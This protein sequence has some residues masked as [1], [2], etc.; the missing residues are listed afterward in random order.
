MRNWPVWFPGIDR[1]ERAEPDTAEIRLGRLPAGI[2]G[3]QCLAVASDSEHREEA[4]TGVIHFLTDTPAQKLLATFGFAPT[5]LD[6]YI[7]AGLQNAAPQGLAMVRNAVEAARP[8]PPEPGYA[9]FAQRFKGTHLR[10]SAPRRAAHPAFRRRPAGGAAMTEGFDLQAWHVSLFTAGAILILEVIVW[11]VLRL[12]AQD[13]PAVEEEDRLSRKRLRTAGLILLA[14]IALVMA[15]AALGPD[16]ADKLAGVT[17]A[18]L[19]GVGVWLAYRSHQE[20]VR[21]AAEIRNAAKAAPISPAHVPP[22]QIPPAQTLPDQTPPAQI[23]PDQTPPAQPVPHGQ[24]GALD[25]PDPVTRR[26]PPG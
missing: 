26:D 10:L 7:D 5:G 20:T 6:A 3:G 2:L 13:Q 15:V 22:D 14:V 17:A 11:A 1:A 9:A 12:R 8:R 19:A 16:L 21:L 23:P 25:Q 24:P 4:E 18:A